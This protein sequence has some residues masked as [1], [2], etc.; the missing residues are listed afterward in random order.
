MTD[1]VCVKGLM[2]SFGE[3]CIHDGLDFHVPKGEIVG[4]AGPSGSGKT[5][6]L[7]IL[8]MIETYDEGEISIL[9]RPIMEGRA[10]R[11][12]VAMMFQKPTLFNESL[13][14]N[15][16]YGMRIRGIPK[17]ER[18]NRAKKALIRLG[19][20]ERAKNAHEISGGEAQRVSFAQV[21]V[22]RP[23]VLLLDE[24]SA[25]LDKEILK[26]CEQMI[27]ELKENGTSVIIASHDDAHLQR[28][29]GTI[30]MLEDGK[31]RKRR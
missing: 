26:T 31:L 28:V 17:K 8:D 4:I 3:R 19:I 11:R 25:N 20:E 10:V 29:C 16:E 5:T 2:K 1:A 12:K 24:P 23:G 21:Y 13:Q 18:Y 27:L 15:V 7:R 9:G 14:S 30:Y 6:L 22:L